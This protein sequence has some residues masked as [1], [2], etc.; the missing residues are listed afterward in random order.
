MIAFASASCR[1]GFLSPYELD[2]LQ[3]DSELP[4]GKRIVIP[5]H[6]YHNDFDAATEA[7]RTVESRMEKAGLPF[8][9]TV[10]YYYPGSNL[11]IGFFWAINRANVAGRHLGTLVRRLQAA[12]NTVSILT[13]SLGARVALTALQ[14]SHVE[15]LVMMAPAVD[16]DCLG[17]EGEFSPAASATNRV[18]VMFSPRDSV[19]RYA[20]RASELFERANFR[21][22]LGLN[23][24]SG[25]VPWN[26]YQIP[27]ID[28]IGGHGE[29]KD[30]DEP[31]VRWNELR[32][33]V[34][35]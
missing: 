7:Y 9:G 12:G 34:N 25:P 21:H 29:Y 14:T 30:R 15:D 11:N 8:D 23:G 16:D 18:I 33:K 27:C 13:H 32:W 5:V 1:K 2:D 22:A 28:F 35:L 17:E 10:R 6:G 24:A 20:Y 4:R 3:I 26:V 31:W 19:L